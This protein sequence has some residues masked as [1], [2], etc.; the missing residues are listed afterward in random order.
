MALIYEK[1]IAKINEEYTLRVTEML[2][3]FIYEGILNLFDRA[4]QMYGQLLKIYSTT[5]KKKYPPKK[6]MVFQNLLATTKDWSRDR[7]MKETNRIKLESENS[8]I[9]DLLIKAVIKS[10]IT[11]FTCGYSMRDAANIFNTY[12]NKIDVGDVIHKCYIYSAKRFYNNAD[13][14]VNDSKEL[15]TANIREIKRLINEG[16][17]EGIWKSLPLEHVLNGYLNLRPIYEDTNL[18]DFKKIKGSSLKSQLNDDIGIDSRSH[19]PITKKSPHGYTT[20]L[21]LKDQS[22]N[23]PSYAGVQNTSREG[24]AVAT[25]EGNMV[26]QSNYSQEPFKQSPNSAQEGD[27]VQE[28]SLDNSQK[29]R[30]S[31]NSKQGNTNQKSLNIFNLVNKSNMPPNFL[32]KN[33]RSPTQTQIT[34]VAGHKLNSFHSRPLKL[35][36]TIV[37]PKSIEPNRTMNNHQASIQNNDSIQRTDTIADNYEVNEDADNSDSEDEDNDMS[38]GGKMKVDK[39][40]LMKIDNT[41]KGH[42]KG[43]SIGI[44]KTL[45]EFSNSVVYKHK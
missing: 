15:S 44:N 31:I 35:S 8:L 3:G 27:G 16:I 18:D 41:I 28:S 21:P 36:P 9:F 13:L 43:N 12:Y 30:T 2:Q 20:G 14:F 6:D 38:G 19:L 11:L 29:T 45:E 17:S 32:D 42:Q 26:V 39:A 10:N 34:Q 4:Q 5:D 7:I 24:N 33:A 37:K 40:L 25:Q 23:N 22:M 1:N